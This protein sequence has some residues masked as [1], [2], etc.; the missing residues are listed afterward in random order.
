MAIKIRTYKKVANT[1]SKTYIAIVNLKNG[2]Q[3]SKTFKSHREAK[4][5]EKEA[6]LAVKSGNAKDFENGSMRFKELAEYWFENHAK[7]YKSPSAIRR[8]EQLLRNQI[9]P[10][11]AK[12]RIDSIQATEVTEWIKSL[13]N[14][15]KLA[16]K[17]ANLCLGLLRKILSDAVK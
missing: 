14:E 8:D 12:R 13:V 7:I 6:R 15:N 1:Q 3:I 10:K 2:K 16:P 17:T 9:L 4:S 5:W 11:F